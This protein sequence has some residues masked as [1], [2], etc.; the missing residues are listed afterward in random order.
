MVFSIVVVTASRNTPEE[1]LTYE[2]SISLHKILTK[3]IM[4]INPKVIA[5][6]FLGK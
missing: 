2:I 5:S 3:I 4:S 6:G 1:V